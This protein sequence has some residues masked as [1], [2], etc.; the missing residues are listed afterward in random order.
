MIINTLKIVY[1]RQRREKIIRVGCE[2]PNEHRAYLAVGS[3]PNM[4]MY[5]A[6]HTARAVKKQLRKR[7]KKRKP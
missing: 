1:A 5:K 2:H 3:K 7:R 6:E 4:P